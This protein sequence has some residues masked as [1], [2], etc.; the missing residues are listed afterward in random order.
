MKISKNEYKCVNC[1]AI[2]NKGIILCPYCKTSYPFKKKKIAAVHPAPRPK[3]VPYRIGKIS[4]IKKSSRNAIFFGI[5]IARIITGFLVFSDIQ[6]HYF[7][8]VFSCAFLILI[9]GLLIMLMLKIRKTG[10]WE[11]L[12]YTIGLSIAFLMFGGLF[13]NLVLPSVGIDEPLSLIPLFISFDIF[14]L[15]FWIIAYK[16]N[17]D[18]SI[19][20]KLTKLD[21]SDKIFFI[22]PVVFPLL[23]ILGA[24]TL[25]NSGPNYLTM[26]MLGGIVIYFFFLVL[27]RKKLNQNIYPWGILMISI[28][29]LL[30]F[31]LRSW[32]L[33][34]GDI[35]LEYY[36]FQLTKSLSHWSSFQFN[37]PYNTCLS[38]TILPTVLSN[39][40]NI[41]GEYIYKVIFP[42]I[43][44][45]SV[46]GLYLLMKK[47]MKNVPSFLSIIFFTTQLPFLLWITAI[48]RQEIALFFFI[49]FL[50]VIFN[51]DFELKIKEILFL[52]FGF[53]LIVSHYSTAYI[54]LFLVSFAF[55][56]SY[57]IK[58]F[59]FRWNKHLRRKKKRISPFKITSNRYFVPLRLILMLL[60][61]A[62]LWYSVF[63][64]TA[65]SLNQILKNNIN[66][67]KEEYKS[68]SVRDAFS[69]NPFSNIYATTDQD[70][71]DYSEYTRATYSEM[72]DL[73]LYQ[74]DEFA[75]YDVSRAPTEI[76]PIPNNLIYNIMLITQKIITTIFKL[77]FFIGTIY[78]LI[79]L[80][81]KKIKVEIIDIEVKIKMK[82]TDIEV[83]MIDIEYLS[84]I[85]GSIII[86]F[87]IILIP[88]ISLEYNFERLYLQTLYIL[89]LPALLGMK[90]ILMPFKKFK[91]DML[92]IL[93]IIV[94]YFLYNTGFATQIVGGEPSEI[95]NNYGTLYIQDYTHDSEV[96]SIEWLSNNRD[97]NSLIYVDKASERKLTAYGNIVEGLKR[98]ILPSAIDKRAY[99]Y[100]GYSN[101][102]DKVILQLFKGK[103]ILY[104]LP[105]NFLS[106]N[107]NLLYNNQ[108]TE[109][110]K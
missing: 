71:V 67:L 4:E 31:S 109:I 62:F 19:E 58:K 43:F 60:L 92:I 11:Y 50:L 8:A 72:E 70:V 23:S 3:K 5:L 88:F 18:I 98:D 47:Y 96:K 44:S 86:L 13:V 32:H 97:K 38:I 21:L 77:S 75:G 64:Q 80:F 82:T 10:I 102:T 66:N 34:G 36:V 20:I 106:N 29:L 51:N 22:V 12:I 90:L 49:L 54:T 104:S 95:L 61:F 9:P 46:I 107:K 40:L 39:F 99:V 17:K 59:I 63:T 56:A 2:L 16:R 41:S 108:Y 35:S 79:I 52:I 87:V 65:V 105:E 25:N 101:V 103:V 15:I 74:P 94:F 78:I 33:T 1:G 45:F 89:V 110:Y 6:L 100:L 24:T 14:L 68:S 42:V 83:Q 91:V 85:I 30:S 27:F 26:I 48:A 55:V 93:L 53:S 7:R 37:D 81:M 57:F 28:S 73:D 69:I 84:L 76:N